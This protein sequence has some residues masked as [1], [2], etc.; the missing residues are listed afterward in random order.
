MCVLLTL[1]HAMFNNNG[2]LVAC[3]SSIEFPSTS[4]V[5]LLALPFVVAIVVGRLSLLAKTFAS[6]FPRR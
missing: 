3:K 2:R 1:Q 4:F 5:I 6:S